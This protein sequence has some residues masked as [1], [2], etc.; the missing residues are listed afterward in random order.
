MLSGSC[1]KLLIALGCCL[2]FGC[3]SG[4]VFVFYKPLSCTACHQQLSGYLHEQL[5]RY[6]LYIVLQDEEEE[7]IYVR[8]LVHNTYQQ[9]QVSMISRQD[10]IQ[11]KTAISPQR[12]DT[13][14]S[15]TPA[16]WMSRK[17]KTDTCLLYHELFDADGVLIREHLRFTK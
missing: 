14:F 13:L 9:Q 15:R 16:M 3:R 5:P 6:R 7:K 17:G 8:R 4:E 2:L 12:V 1:T 11:K 10:L